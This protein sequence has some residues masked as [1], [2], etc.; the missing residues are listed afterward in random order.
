[1]TTISNGS[2]RPV[3][4]ALARVDGKHLLKSPL[5]LAGLGAAMLGTAVFV[6]ET[7]TD[8]A[9]TWSNDAW[10]IGAGFILAA[11]FAMLAVNR[12]SLRD[13]REHTGEQHGS[14]PTNQTLRLAGMFGAVLWPAIVSTLLLG[15][16]VEFA[17]TQ[18]D[19]PA[20]TIVHV[21]HN[22]AVFLMLGS[23]GLT[24]A[25]WIPSSFAAPVVAFALYFIHPGETP[26]AWHVIWP[27]ASLSTVELATW[28][29]VYLLGLALLLFA[30][31]ATRWERG[32]AQAIVFL[33]SA[34]T[35]AASLTVLVI[36]ACPQAGRCL[37]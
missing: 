34:A 9:T 31:A 7:L 4:L 6:R 16:V 36:G 2:A 5:F 28:H 22:A 29:I 27:F 12:A 17:S 18:V 20:I 8:E 33:G 21:L 19:V 30:T 25:A 26:A 35:V 15:V 3:T 1:M 32:R 11:V 24:L 10:T 37:L 23:A 13:H 14:L